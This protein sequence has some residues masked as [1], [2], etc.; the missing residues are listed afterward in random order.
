MMGN[1]FAKGPASPISFMRSTNTSG[2][3]GQETNATQGPFGWSSYMHP[4]PTAGGS[5]I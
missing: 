5:S 1:H 3:G 2:I 4:P